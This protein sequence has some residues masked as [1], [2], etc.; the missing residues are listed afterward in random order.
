V[1]PGH[2]G[3]AGGRDRHGQFGSLAEK[4]YPHVPF[5]EV[6]QKTGAQFQPFEG[7]AVVGQ[8]DLVFRAAVD[9]FED[10]LGQAPA[11]ILAKVRDVVTVIQTRHVVF[12][13]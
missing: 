1:I 10:A 8:G 9:I 13:L 2:A 7:F 12:P 4:V 6:D 5:A 3:D 11:R